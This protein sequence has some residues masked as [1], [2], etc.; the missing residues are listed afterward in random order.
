[1]KKQTIVDTLEV[2][3]IFQPFLANNNIVLILDNNIN[4]FIPRLLLFINVIKKHVFDTQLVCQT[5]FY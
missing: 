2:K 4:V 3:I 5:K 1:M